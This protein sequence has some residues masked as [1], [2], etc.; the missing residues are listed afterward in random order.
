[1]KMGL[2]GNGFVGNAIYENLK[3]RYE[4]FVFDLNPERKTCDSVRGVRK[5]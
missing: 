1:M 5:R 2:I 4:F 3:Q